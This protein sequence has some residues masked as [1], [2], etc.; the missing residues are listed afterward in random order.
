MDPEVH[1]LLRAT[2][3]TFRERHQIPN[4]LFYGPSGAGKRTLV[5]EFVRAIYPAVSDLDTWTMHVDCD[6]PGRGI[7][8]IRDDLHVF[9]AKQIAHHDGRR[10]KIVVLLNADKLTT[11]AQSALRRCIEQTSHNT[12][13]FLVAQD[14]NALMDPILSRVCAMHV[15]RPFVPSLGCTVNLC[16]HHVR[17][18]F[19]T[20][21]VREELLKGEL[22]RWGVSAHT[23]PADF[24]ALA[25]HLYEKAYS[26]VDFLALVSNDAFL[27]AL[28]A[29]RR[30]R[31]CVVFDRV[32]TC[33]RNECL[34][35]V[36]MLWFVYAS[37]DDPLENLH[38]F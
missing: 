30:A 16:K 31:L 14:K 21:T 18:A 20:P 15:P 7:K 25:T 27:P 13:Y 4:L 8:Y 34:M 28:S 10:F 26:V 38:V 35:W 24:P 5:N 11:E 22:E 37:S 32:R 6:H 17:K 12:R 1:A 33:V 9:V 29:D 3:S 19:P 23:P 2:L 36:Y